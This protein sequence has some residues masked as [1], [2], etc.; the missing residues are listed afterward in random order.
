MATYNSKFWLKQWLCH[1]L[2]WEHVGNELY[3]LLAPTASIPKKIDILLP[4]ITMKHTKPNT[5]FR[6]VDLPL[7]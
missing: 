7:P 5:S 3:L 6:A 1:S 4:N 2:Y